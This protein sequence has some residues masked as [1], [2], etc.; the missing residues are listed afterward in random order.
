MEIP[1]LIEPVAGNG[2]RARGVEPFGLSAEGATREEVLAK[3]QQQLQE[4]LQHGAQ[5]LSLDVAGK[6]A[7][8]P[9]SEFAGMN[10]WSEFAGMFKDDP[11]FDEW[12]QAIAENRRKIDEDPD[13]P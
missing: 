5:L 1:V 9:W 6:D 8:N 13:S 12:Q 10:P 4:R 3:L 7:R 11:Y 2:Y